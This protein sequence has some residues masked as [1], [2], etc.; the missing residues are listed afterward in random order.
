MDDRKL[1]KLFDSLNQNYFDDKIPPSTQV[2]FG[3]TTKNADGN[4]RPIENKIVIHS[5]LKKH[6]I[7]TTICVLHEMAHAK[8]NAVYVGGNYSDDPHHGMIYQAELVR[9]FN[10]GAY[11]G[12]L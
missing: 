3:K 10:A 1:K 5:S 2:V 9:L 8:L 12:L 6:D 11:D 4:Y 7:L